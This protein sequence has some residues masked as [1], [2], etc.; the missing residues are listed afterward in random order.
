MDYSIFRHPRLRGGHTVDREVPSES[1]DMHIHPELEII[2]VIEGS[3]SFQSEGSV[4]HVGPGDLILFRLSEAH[5]ILKK[6]DPSTYERVTFHIEPNLLKE[7]LNGRL[8]KPFTDR[9]LGISNHYSAG[10]LPQELIHACLSQIFGNQPMRNDMQALS[11][12]LPILQCIYDAYCQK[13]IV[14]PTEPT[15]L[16]SRM[17]A[18]INAHLYELEGPHELEEQFFMSI[19]QI[20]RIFHAFTGSTVWNY[21]KLK[22]LHAA[23]EMLES[24]VAPM[25]AAAKCG[26][27]DYSAFFRAYK[28]QFGHPPKDDHSPKKKSLE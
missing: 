20:N 25:T 14:L 1:M 28:K 2:Y 6:T 24:G 7:T 16:A 22:R 26:Y 13:Q 9:P 12:L 5:S 10:E 8:L 15:P 27:Q 18:Y 23:R 11:Y 4:Y 17:I 21:V 3:L 19:S